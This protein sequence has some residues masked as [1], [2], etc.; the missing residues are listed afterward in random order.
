MKIALL[1]LPFDNNFGGNLQRYALMKTLE[2]MGHEIYHLDLEV[3][4]SLRWYVKPYSYAKRI[5]QKYLLGKDVKVFYENYLNDL[6][7][8]KNKN[9]K[10]FYEQY[11]KHTIPFKD[12]QGLKKIINEGFD[13]YIVGSDQVWRESMTH[14]LGIENYFLSFVESQS[15][16]RIA[17]AVSMGSDKEELSK[18]KI[19]ELGRLY[20]LF[21]AVSVR[22]KF[23]L[24]VL[25]NY[26]WS[27]PKAHFV[28]DPTF[29]LT[30]ADYEKL[31]SEKKIEKA[32]NDYIF[33]Y[34]LD[35]PVNFEE[36]MN[37]VSERWKAPF[38][39]QSL[40]DNI[41]IEEWLS[42]IMNSKLVVT[43]SYHGCVFSILFHRPFIFLGNERRGNARVCS[44]FEVFH[45]DKNNT[46]RI[47]YSIVD[48][49][50]K[51]MKKNSLSFISNSL[52]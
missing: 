25:K 30:P 28:L 50:L 1:N 13:A 16:R 29:L 6:V 35:K 49:Y 38:I 10:E 5:L 43:D 15:V 3:Y 17:Y 42:K 26:G 33:C 14:Q 20:A 39:I 41:L 44:L 23:S 4:Y 47:N 2:S 32:I 7:K 51:E 37:R 8:K 18:D 22:E 12:K 52:K 9:A 40:N 34:I 36:E 27:Q 11:V 19:K 24:D 21:D 48:D 31:I 45:I 46:E